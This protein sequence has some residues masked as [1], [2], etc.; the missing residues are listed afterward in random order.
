[1]RYIDAEKLIKAIEEK[2]LDCS[3]ALKM[4]RL[5]TLALID[6]LQQEQIDMGEVS[7]GYHTFNELYYYRMLYNAAFF[8]LL[9]KNM[10]HKSKRHHTGEEC[11]GGGWFIVMANLPTGQISNH[12]ELKD[13]NLFKVPEKEIADEWDGHTPQEAAKRIKKYL[14][15][16]DT[17]EDKIK[18]ATESWKGVDVDEFM[19]EVRGR[20]QEQLEVD[21]S[22]ETITKEFHIIS[23]RCFNEGVEGWQKEKLIARHFYELGLN[24]KKE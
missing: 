7:D 11:F 22:E 21:L 13:W 9:P 2:G 12:Y 10:A 15:L 4:E 23:D 5:D 24:A 16:P 18:R 1:M 6:E 3:F 8:N 14:Q 17:P 19:N 20:E